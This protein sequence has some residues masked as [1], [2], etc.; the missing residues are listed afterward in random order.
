MTGSNSN[1]SIRRARCRD[2]CFWKPSCKY[3]V[4][5]T[6]DQSGAGVLAFHIERTPLIDLRHHKVALA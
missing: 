2:M 1:S 3:V 6:A 5:N 4:S